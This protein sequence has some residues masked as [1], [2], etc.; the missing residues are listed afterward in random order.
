MVIP[1]G[2]ARLFGVVAPVFSARGAEALRTAESFEP[3]A[4]RRALGRRS[5]A[6]S[7]ADGANPFGP[8]LETIVEAISFVGRC[9][10]V[11]H[12]FGESHFRKWV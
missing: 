8:R 7:G 5:L 1:N 6:T 12:G 9:R 3:Q 4:G 11:S 10:V 2:T